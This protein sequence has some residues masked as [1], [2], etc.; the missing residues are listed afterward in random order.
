MPHLTVEATLNPHFPKKIFIPPASPKGYSSSPLADGNR[1]HSYLPIHI[2]D[3]DVLL[4]IGI[5]WAWKILT[6]VAP[7]ALLS[8]ECRVDD[9]FRS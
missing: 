6:P 2:L 8:P 9:H 1:C 3:R 4:P 5:V 7:A